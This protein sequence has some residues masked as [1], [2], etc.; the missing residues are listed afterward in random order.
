[1][2]V[3]V[4]SIGNKTLCAWMIKDYIWLKTIFKI[5]EFEIVVLSLALFFSHNEINLNERKARISPDKKK[6]KKDKL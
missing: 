3:H 6:T 2:L 1:M 5:L 4:I